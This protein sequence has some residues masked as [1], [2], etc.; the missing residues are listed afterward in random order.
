MVEEFLLGE[1]PHL[2]R[3]EVND[4]AGVP[5]EEGF[6]LWRLLGFPQTSDDDEAFT[7]AD[8]EALRQASDLARLG[9]LD[10]SSRA[11]LVRTWGRSFARLAEWQTTLLADLATS[12]P[13]GAGEGEAAERL[14]TL[15][16]EILPR[17]DSLQSYV[18][19]RHLASAANRLFTSGDLGSGGPPAEVHQA[20]CFCD[21]VGF[22][23]RSKELDDAELVAWLE[24]FEDASTALI[25]EHGGRVI[26]NIGDEVLFVVD[27]P[28]AAARIALAL[29]ARGED[30]DDEFPRVRAGVAYG[31]VV[32]RLGDV[33]GPTVNIAAR[34]T[35]VARPGTVLV[36][37]GMH[38]ALAGEAS[39][40]ETGHDRETETPA[41]R[42]RRLHRT[43]VKGYSRLRPWSL[44]EP[45]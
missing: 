29:V 28:A 34:L 40:E 21:I 20:V 27:A 17:I 25:V 5:Q 13:D 4:L 8:V 22:T 23:S 1:R 43:P 38:E 45:R 3:L 42:W 33:F 44:R 7:D 6:E 37:D 12:A 19:R 11:A 18:W 30:D 36:D 2:T 41:Y 31:E 24:T 10:D 35:S 15:A 39:D 14:V 16:A 9:V 26:K 32:A